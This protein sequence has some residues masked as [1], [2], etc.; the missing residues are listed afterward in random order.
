MRFKNLWRQINEKR[1]VSDF[2]RYLA[3]GGDVNT[4][5]PESGWTLLH[6]AAELGNLS[7]IEALVKSGANLNARNHQGWTPLHLAVDAQID[8]VCQSSKRLGDVKF[9]TVRLLLSLGA[10]PAIRDELGKTPRDVAAAYGFDVA[11]HFDRL[12]S[13]CR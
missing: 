10:D 7:L 11:P 13:T 8:V 1:G 3:A 12:T 6:N 9:P 4:A 2:Y 5:H